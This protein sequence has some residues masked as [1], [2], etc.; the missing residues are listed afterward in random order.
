MDNLRLRILGPTDNKNHRKRWTTTPKIRYG[1]KQNRSLDI[2]KNIRYR[3]AQVVKGITGNL[4]SEHGQGY[5]PLL[6]RIQ[7]EQGKQKILLD[8]QI[9]L[10]TT[11]IEKFNNSI[12]KLMITQQIFEKKKSPKSSQSSTQL[13][14]RETKFTHFY[15]CTQFLSR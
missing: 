7:T 1:Q 14:P 10:T 13:F 6:S 2:H 3:N 15:I 8:E 4:G 12:A 5:Q 11:V 9:C